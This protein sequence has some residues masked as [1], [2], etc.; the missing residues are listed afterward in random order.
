MYKIILF[1]NLRF[2][3]MSGVRKIKTMAGDILPIRTFKLKSMDAQHPSIVMIAKRGSGKSVAVKAVLKHFEDIPMGLVISKTD[4]MSSFYGKFFPDSYIFYEYKSEIIEKILKR[5]EAII[6]KKEEKE[7]QGKKVDSRAFIVMDDCLS[8]K[9]SWV[10]DQPIAE[11]LF[12]GRHY[13][14]MYILT[15]QFPLGITPELRL[16]FDYVFLLADDTTSNIKR[17]YDH[18][19]GIFPNLEAFK[20][21]FM[22]L[23]ANFGCMVIANRGARTNLLDKVFYYKADEY[24]DDEIDIGCEQFKKF[25]MK[26]YNKDWKKKSKQIDIS[27]FCTKSKNKKSLIVDKV[28]DDEKGR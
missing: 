12:N 19:A 4:K 15:M 17:I 8:S 11:L 24:R 10:R 22:Q 27:Q 14:I 26:N 18:Y 9:G 25:H 5:Q 7:K 21:A 1:Y 13:H 20:Q 6:D 28:D 3:S 2:Y 23:T 16:N